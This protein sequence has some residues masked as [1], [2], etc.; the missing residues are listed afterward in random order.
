MQG[1]YQVDS[2]EMELSNSRKSEAVF[3][4]FIKHIL[5]GSWP[6]AEELFSLHK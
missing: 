4:F 1:A 2:A 3:V 5:I 6:V